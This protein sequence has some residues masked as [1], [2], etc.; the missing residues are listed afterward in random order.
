LLPGIPTFHAD[1]FHGLNQRVDRRPA[2]RVISTFHDLFVITGE[3]SSPG[4][5]HRFTKQARRAAANSDFI[6]AVS[7]FTARQVEKLLGFDATRIRVVHHGVRKP[8]MRRAVSR[9][10]TVLFVGALQARK[11]VVRLVDA[12]QQMPSDW[13][14]VL[15]GSICGY[16]VGEI[17][18]RI[19][20]SCCSDRIQVTGYVSDDALEELYARASIFAFP[21]LDEG[22]GMPVLEAMARGVPVVTS[23]A[24]ALKEVA[25]EAAILVDPASVDEI[26]AALR[27]LADDAELRARL[28]NKG[29]ARAAEFSWERAI[30]KTYSVYEEVVSRN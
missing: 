16:G 18:K 6:I 15:A 12:F 14:L 4:F 10:R 21:S 30:T 9:E 22:F 5:R 3:Y 11:N 20:G 27:M 29:L 28:I 13:R 25:G 23:N 17:M 19:A 8:Q 24:S 26:G 7:A 1:V 2:Q